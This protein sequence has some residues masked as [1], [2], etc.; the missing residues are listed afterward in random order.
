MKRAAIYARVSTPDQNL[1]SQLAQCRAYCDR[2]DVVIYKEFSDTGSGVS[3]KRPEFQ[4]LMQ[5]SRQR[6]FD[7]LVVLRFDRFARSTKELVNGL[8]ELRRLGISFVSVQEAIDTSTPAGEAL[9]TVIAAFAQFER[10][11]IQE[12]VKVGLWWAKEKGIKLGR[13]H[14]ELNGEEGK[15]RE[16]LAQGKTVRMIAQ[17]LGISRHIVSK[18]KSSVHEVQPT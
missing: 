1:E 4:Q 8:E 11:I 7:V 5:E 10:R 16:L 6:M 14:K 18:I 12:R 9:F 3:S 2:A 15:I 13:P 17:E